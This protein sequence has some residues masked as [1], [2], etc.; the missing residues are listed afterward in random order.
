MLNKIYITR[1]F[2]CYI[3][4]KLLPFTFA[5]K[6]KVFQVIFMTLYIVLSTCT[7]TD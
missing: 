2:K 4:T 6:I 5:N 7:Q 3:S 1:K